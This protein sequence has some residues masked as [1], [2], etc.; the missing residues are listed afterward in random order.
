MSALMNDTD[1]DSSR[2]QLLD[3]V[4]ASWTTQAIRAACLLRLPEHLATTIPVAS[5][6]LAVAMD[7]HA[8]SLHR[9]LHAL[10]T[11]ALC[12]EDEQGRFTLTPMGELLREDH[13]QSV[14][15][16]A[17][18][19][20]GTIWQRWAELDQSVRS[21]LSQRRRQGSA[22]GFDN[23]AQNRAAAAQFHSAMVAIT[24]PIAAP[25]ARAIDPARV[26]LVVDVGGGNGEL[27]ST[28]LA[29]HPQ[30]RGV[31]F[32][33]P[34]GLDGAAGVLERFGVA[35]RCTCV[36]GSFFEGVP[37]GG[38]LYLLKSVLH[39]WDDDR[40]VEILRRCRDAMAPHGRVLVVER[41]M[42]DR[43]GTSAPDPP[44]ARSDLN[45]LVALSGRERRAAEFDALFAAAGLSRPNDCGPAGEYRMLQ[46]GAG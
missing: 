20:G 22:D 39:N 5:T 26:R 29:H 43:T 11:L 41:V 23:L 32:D 42:A 25:V 21:G 10:A 35:A 3:M 12:T 4:N 46:A 38:D 24:R 16:W 14:R 1:V 45:M 6:D 9:L 19:A 8:A 13:P 33:L 40:S 31:L 7:C 36:P 44:G 17:L 34:H 28:V 27:L 15:A 37:P 30:L 18:L 2:A